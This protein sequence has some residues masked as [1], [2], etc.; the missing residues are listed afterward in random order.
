MNKL[1]NKDVKFSWHRT[2]ENNW[3]ADDGQWVMDVTNWPRYCFCPYEADTGSVVLGMN[4]ISERCPGNLAGI[5]HSVGG[6]FAAT[7]AREN[8]NWRERYAPNDGA[9][10][11]DL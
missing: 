1:K 11:R 8:P 5:Y 3:C 2:Q 4:I 9:E 6:D 10:A 7:W